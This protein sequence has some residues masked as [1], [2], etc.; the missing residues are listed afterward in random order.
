VV[1]GEEFLLETFIG[2]DGVPDRATAFVR[3][4]VTRGRGP[5][6][7]WFVNVYV[8]CSPRSWGWSV[9]Y[10]ENL[11]GVYVLPT[12]VG[13]I[14]PPRSGSVPYPLWARRLRLLIGVSW[15]G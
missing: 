1:Q 8:T 9:V 2:G 15:T 6:D 7:N 5:V 3:S 4:G 11:A 13:V 12:P 10:L 14:R